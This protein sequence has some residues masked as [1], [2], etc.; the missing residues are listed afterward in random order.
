MTRRRVLLL[1]SIAVVAALAVTGW[2]VSRQ[3][4]ITRENA[5]RI[6][7]DMTLAEVEA[8]LGGPERDDSTGPTEFD[9]DRDNLVYVITGSDLET[10][11][12]T[13]H[14]WHTDTVSI[15]VSSSADG[16]VWAVDKRP[17][18]RQSQGALDTLRRWLHL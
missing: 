16:H 12:L 4:A 7:E 10:R 6:S 14:W 1:G 15:G 11:P 18:R 3:S 2:V 9:P 8:I 13:V 5:A 17:M